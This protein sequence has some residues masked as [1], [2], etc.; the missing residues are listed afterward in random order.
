MATVSLT[1]SDLIIINQRVISDLADGDVAN[2]EFP[3]NIAEVKTGKNGNSIY[4]LNESGKNSELTLRVIRGSGDDKFL[5]QLLSNQNINFAS[6][7][8]MVG[9][10]VKKVGDGQGNITNDTYVC[11]GGI[12]MKL[13][14]AKSNV[15]GDTGQSV[16]EYKIKFSNTPRVLT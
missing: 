12:F 7:V 8:L 16:S 15:D 9:E 13:V 4:A 11:A 14:P 10:F 2:L 3:N 1:G 6:T 5:N